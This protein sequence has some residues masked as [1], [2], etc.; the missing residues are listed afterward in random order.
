[1]SCAFN[2]AH[3]SS[4]HPKY[5]EHVDCGSAVGSRGAGATLKTLAL[6]FLRTVCGL[7]H[8]FVFSPQAWGPV[9]HLCE[10]LLFLAKVANLQ[11]EAGVGMQQVVAC[12]RT[13][14]YLPHIL[15][16]VT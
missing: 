7:G 4:C 6:L 15:Q 14:P 10:F 3:S 13:E 16:F 2:A 11:R 9:A 1:M 5:K 12:L 8:Q